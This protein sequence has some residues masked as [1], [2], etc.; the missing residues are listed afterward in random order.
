V[1]KASIV[2]DV[3]QYVDC[4]VPNPD[5]EAFNWIY[6]TYQEGLNYIRDG[7]NYPIEELA[8]NEVPTNNYIVATI[9]TQLQLY[10]PNFETIEGTFIDQ[11]QFMLYE[12]AR[13]IISLSVMNA[14]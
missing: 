10:N 1:S 14:E 9:W 6:N 12:V 5:E 13:E 8:E 7:E 2:Y 3:C 11:F 4:G